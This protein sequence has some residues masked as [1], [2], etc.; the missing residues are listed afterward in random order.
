MCPK[1]NDMK[2]KMSATEFLQNQYELKSQLSEMDFLIAKT[3]EESKPKINRNLPK[4]NDSIILKS[5]YDKFGNRLFSL[6]D[7]HQLFD[8]LEISK[9]YLGQLFKRN[10][11]KRIRVGMIKTCCYRIS[12]N[13][14]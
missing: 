1:T 11:M 10:N 4:E 14:S 3:I 6:N 8:K 5:I 13:F 12:E 7:C 9:K 2:N